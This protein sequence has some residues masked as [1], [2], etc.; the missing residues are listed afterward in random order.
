M[1]FRKTSCVLA[2]LFAAPVSAQT[3]DYLS[4]SAETELGARYYFEDGAFFGQSDAGLYPYFGVRLNA[5]LELEDGA[6]IGEIS[7]LFD[8]F[9]ER[10]VLNI[11]R[12]Y[13]T[14]SFDT[15]DYL[16]GY[17]V[18]DWGVS[19]GRTIVN[20]LNSRDRANQV[21]DSELLGTPMLNANFFTQIGTFSVYALPGNT[22]ENF[23]GLNSRYRGPLYTDDDLIAYETDNPLNFAVRFTNNYAVGQGA[24]DVGASFY[25]GADRESVGLLG[26]NRPGPGVDAAT[27][28]AITAASIANFESGNAAPSTQA[29]IDAFLAT[30]FGPGVAA[31]AVNFGLLASAPYYQDINQFGLTTVYTQG[32]TQLR[33]EGFVRNTEF[34]TFSGAI[35]GG[36]YTFNDFMGGAGTL[37][38]SA[39]YHYDNRSTRQPVTAFA[40]DVFLAAAYS[41]NDTNDTRIDA[42]VFIDV[43][44]DAQLFTL[45]ASRRL[46]DNVS[47]GMHAS[48]VDAAPSNDPLS[49]VDDDSFVEFS[50]SIFF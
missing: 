12:L 2:C 25:I 44:D 8:D 7:G 46:G 38:V 47:L 24:L 29:E 30:N 43:D 21:G 31:N 16:I 13:Y 35:V 1:N 22:I 40:D 50:L 18:E 32:N 17:N 49:F 27:C 39:E 23:G 42:S 9:N 34:E 41:A 37:I 10:S 19:N 3:S 15:W 4:L 45:G 5:D 20:V 48:H 6:I 28:N 11:Q 26:C 33:F 36:D 14:S